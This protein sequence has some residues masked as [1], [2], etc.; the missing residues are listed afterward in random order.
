[1]KLWWTGN[2]GG[3]DENKSKDHANKPHSKPFGQKIRP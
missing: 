1:M 3:V 2:G